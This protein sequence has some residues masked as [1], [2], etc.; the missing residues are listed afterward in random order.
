MNKQHSLQRNRLAT[1][2]L[3]LFALDRCLKMATIVH[4][5]RRPRPAL[6]EHWPAVTLFQPITRGASG[7]AHNLRSRTLVDYAGTI[8]HLFICDAADTGSQAI[9]RTLLEE[10]PGLQA[11]IILVQPQQAE[12]ASKLDKLYAGLPRAQG[13]V[14]WFLDDDVALRPQALQILIPYLFQ[15]RVGAAFGLAC[16]TNWDTLWSSL[17]S[18]FVNANALLNYLPITYLTPPFTITGHCFALRRQVFEQVGGFTG[19]EESIDDD[20]GLAR[21]VRAAGLACVQ[22]PL[23]YD[24]NNHLAS[25]HEYAKQMK[26]WFVMPR[27]AMLPYL[28]RREQGFSLLSSISQVFP[29]LLALIVILTLKRS[30]LRALIASL[31]LFGAIYALCELAF[32]QRCTPLRRWP[33]VPLIAL[34]AP[35]QILWS[36]LSNDEIE[37][38]GQRLRIRVGGKVEV[39]R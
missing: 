11:E 13:E 8:Q 9:C 3:A 27:Q 32:L 34:F 36:L 5:F 10:T 21:H 39:L 26:R 38:R 7:L 28:T 37:W 29:T 35:L 1:G 20:H 17:M 30:A 31:G 24:V 18:C 33:L 16:Y 23:I 6:P 12:V 19:L 4:F 15:T 14:F 2:L 25:A 22:T